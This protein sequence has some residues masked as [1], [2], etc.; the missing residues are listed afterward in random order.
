M[1]R[2]ELHPDAWSTIIIHDPTETLKKFADIAG[3]KY[4]YAELDDFSDLIARTSQGAPET[5]K[6]ERRG[7]QQQTIY[8]EFSQDR[9][10]AYGLQPADPGKL[11]QA[12]NI[13]APGGIFETGQRQ[14]TLNPS[15]QFERSQRDCRYRCDH[16]HRRRSGLPPRSGRYKPRI[17]KPCELPELRR[18]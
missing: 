8:L 10:A 6:V 12:R 4:S 3:D 7:V 11:I 15:G 5:S 13:I 18:Q 16:G 14:I 1:Q 2:S 17:L 9:L